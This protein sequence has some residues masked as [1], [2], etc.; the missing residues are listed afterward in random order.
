MKQERVEG[1]IRF[2]QKGTPSTRLD[3]KYTK[4]KSEMKFLIYDF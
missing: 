2:V 3:L 1:V 4:N